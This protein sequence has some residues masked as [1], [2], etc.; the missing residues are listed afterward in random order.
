MDADVEKFTDGEEW[1]GTEEMRKRKLEEYMDEVYGL[2]FNDIVAGMPTRFKYA[3]VQ[4]QSFALTPAEI[5]L[6][7]DAELNQYMGIKKYAPYRK[8]GANWDKNRAARLHEL[9]AKINQRR[10][11]FQGAGDATTAAAGTDVAQERP[12]KKRKGKKER[13]R[14][15]MVAD[16]QDEAATEEGREDNGDDEKQEEEGKRK[17]A[18]ERSADAGSRVG[19]EKERS[20]KRRR[21]HKKTGQTDA[22]AS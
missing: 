13:M 22:V 19:E 18:E 4:A 20:K 10:A 14:A 21:H 5:L 3:K 8:E 6:A 2:E 16:A 15:K 7:T 11:A 17:R 9:K 12:A 1:D